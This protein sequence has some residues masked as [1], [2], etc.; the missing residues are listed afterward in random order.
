MKGLRPLPPTPEKCRA[1]VGFELASS[2]LRLT[3]LPSCLSICGHICACA[4]W[5]S[6]PEGSG[7][8]FDRKMLVGTQNNSLSV[9]NCS[10]ACT[11]VGSAGSRAGF[12]R[13]LFVSKQ[14]S[15]FSASNC[16]GTSTAAG[17]EGSPDQDLAE[18]SLSASKTTAFSLQTVP[19]P[20][21][22]PVRKPLDQ[23]FAE[24][25]L[26][27]SKTQAFPLQTAPGQDLKERCLTANKTKAFPP[28]NCP[29]AIY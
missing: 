6:P 2:S 26:S 9:L 28:Q 22:R 21:R 20:P 17:S 16:S 3:A 14:N 7:T 11:A 23:D 13:K 19:E 1:P 18:N 25:C 4:R 27:G 12:C 29:S 8:R 10:G 24:T 5:S 15:R